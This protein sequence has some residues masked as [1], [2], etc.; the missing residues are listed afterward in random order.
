[1]EKRLYINRLLFFFICFFVIFSF[2]NVSRAASND[3]QRI[4]DFAKLLTPQ[5][6][7]ELE[8]LSAKY[9]A[10][11]ETDFIIL[12]T[13]DTGDSD[14]VGYMEDFYDENGLGYDKDHGNCGI[15]TV[16]MHNREVYLAGFYKAETY[17]DDSRLDRIRNKITPDLSGGDYY[18]AFRTFIKTS[19]KYMG[20]RPGVNPD[21]ILFNLWFQIIVSLMTAGIIVG[22][23]AYSSGGRMTVGGSTY[24]DGRRSRIIA[25]RDDYIR[26]S[27]TRHKKPST[28]GNGTGGFMGG[29]GG[30]TG[31][32]HSHSGSRG[33]F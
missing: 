4:Y 3:K 30:I 17:L 20:V 11:R 18:N 16:D 15:L 27:T 21:N 14:V 9:S 2:V 33:S 28:D 6:I 23:M 8:E 25:R 10:K 22:F 24:K 12:T 7:E 19:Y 31:G 32:G 29:G 26:T 5:E 1:M 13:D